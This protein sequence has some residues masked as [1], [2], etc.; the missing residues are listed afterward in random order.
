MNILVMNRD[1]IQKAYFNL[2][3]I[4]ISMTDDV[5]FFP[6]IP[7]RNCKGIL[8]VAVWDTEDG[9]HYRSL[10]NFGAPSIP[11]DKIFSG[12]HAKSI[13]EFVFSHVNKVEL[14][15]CQ[16]D[17]GLSRSASTAAALS[18]ILNGNEG[19]FLNPP[20][21]PNRLIYNTIINEY[22]HARKVQFRDLNEV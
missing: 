20:Y 18:K 9:V 7:E 8:R 5:Q 3:H 22:Y 21:F 4:V 16:C 14:I 11:K 2:S 12:D 10:H 1:E 17:A 19:K 15:V 13:L 6:A